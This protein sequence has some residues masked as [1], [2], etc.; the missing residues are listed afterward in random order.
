M[1]KLCVKMILG[2]VAC[3]ALVSAAHASVLCGP[4]WVQTGYYAGQ[5]YWQTVC[6]PVY[7]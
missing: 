2:A 3:A 4:V 5:G 7:P 6:T 1:K